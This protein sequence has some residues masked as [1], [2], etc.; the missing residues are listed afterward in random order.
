VGTNAVADRPASVAVGSSVP[1]K[2]RGGRVGTSAVGVP[3]G[4]KITVNV[5]LGVGNVKG[6]GEASPGSVHET[7]TALSSNRA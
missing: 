2:I 6:V 3:V 1:V 7:A 4:A 5:R